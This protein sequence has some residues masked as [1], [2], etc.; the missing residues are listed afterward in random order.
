MRHFTNGV[1]QIF[2]ASGRMVKLKNLGFHSRLWRGVCSSEQG[3]LCLIRILS[4]CPLPSVPFAVLYLAHIWLLVPVSTPQSSRSCLSLLAQQ[5]LVSLLLT[6]SPILCPP[7]PV[8][9]SFSSPNSV[10]DDLINTTM[11]NMQCIVLYIL[12]SSKLWA[13]KDIRKICLITYGG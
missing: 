2:S 12:P 1:S 6:S 3:R 11:Y 8:S 13:D 4:A 5:M 10:H 7:G 9:L